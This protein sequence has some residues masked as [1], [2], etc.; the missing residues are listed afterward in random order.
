MFGSLI[1]LPVIC[2]SLVGKRSVDS[3]VIAVNDVF[4][5]QPEG[6]AQVVVQR[7]AVV[8]ATLDVERAEVDARP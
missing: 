1:G 7:H 6:P 4:V 8:A 5:A 3:P 2:G